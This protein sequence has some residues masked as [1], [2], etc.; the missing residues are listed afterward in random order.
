MKAWAVMLAV[1]FVVA[2]ALARAAAPPPRL[3]CDPLQLV[4]C[5]PSLIY[6]STP[7]SQCCSGLEQEQSCLCGY[8][9]NPLLQT[10][11]TIYY[12]R[13][14]QMVSSCQ[15]PYPACLT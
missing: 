4:P 6:A 11:Y 14:V 15:I 13:I 1:C 2:P 12:T 3:C 9:S 8:I 5:V 7:T 10:Y